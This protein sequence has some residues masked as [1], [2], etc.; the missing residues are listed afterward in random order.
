[1][2]GKHSSILGKKPKWYFSELRCRKSGAAEDGIYIFF[3]IRVILCD[4]YQ[5]YKALTLGA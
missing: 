5:N 3:S 2:R 1:M 4:T